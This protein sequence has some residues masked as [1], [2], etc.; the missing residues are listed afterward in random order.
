MTRAVLAFLIALTVAHPAGAAPSSQHRLSTPRTPGNATSDF[1]GDGYED[2][3][4]SA[5]TEDVNGVLDAGAVSV[6]YGSTTGLASTGNQLWTEND[7]PGS[8]GAQVEMLFGRSLATGDL[9]ADGYDDLVIGIP[10]QFIA[11]V[12]ILAGAI[13]VLY[14]GPTGLTLDG[15]Q[16]FIEDDLSSSDGSEAGDLFGRSLDIADFNGD[17]YGDLAIGSP[18]DD[19]SLQFDTGAVAVMYG[20]A[21]GLTPTGNQFFSQDTPGMLDECEPNEWFGW[22][23]SGGD[24]NGDGYDDLAIGDPGENPTAVNQAGAAAIIH[25]SASGLTTNGNQL[26]SE[27]LLSSTDGPEDGDFMGRNVRTANFNGDAYADLVVGIPS[28]DVGTVRDAGSVTVIYGSAAGLTAT[29]NQ[30]W[31]QDSPNIKDQAETHD[32]FGRHEGVGDFNGDGYFDLAVGAVSED[33]GTVQDAGAVNV[34]YGSAAGLTASRNQFWTQ[35]SSHVKGVAEAFDA[36]GRA[37]TGL[38]FNGDGFDDL[39]AGVPG[40]YVGGLQ[41]AGAVNILYGGATGVTADRNQWWNQ[42]SP[43]MLHGAE[44]GALFGAGFPG[45]AAGGCG[46]GGTCQD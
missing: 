33:V 7:I 24:F 9:N 37:V 19:I 46:Q 28:E 44:A 23:V 43:G 4:V 34:I 5:F 3:A 2:L 42:G 16:F 26:W 22:S 17:G 10:H 30:F 38:D 29:G 15:N 8:G 27:D 36:M 12:G 31:N 11:G 25:G 14:G 6:M 32:L 13:T 40:D 35:D 1:N 45:Q 39:A 41:A 20:S 21:A 18:K